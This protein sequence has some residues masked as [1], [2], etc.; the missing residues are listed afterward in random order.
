MLS[1]CTKD[2]N[3]E[4]TTKKVYSFYSG[5]GTLTLETHS[6]KITVISE[7][8]YKYIAYS[9]FVKPFSIAGASTVSLGK[10][11]FISAG[12]FFLAAIDYVPEVEKPLFDFEEDKRKMIEAR[13]EN[14]IK[15]YPEFHKPFTKNHIIVEKT[16]SKISAYK[17]K[18]E[19][20]V[21]I[22]YEKNEYDNSI[23]VSREI[24]KDYYSTVY[25]INHV[26]NVITI[27]VSLVS[28]VSG[29]LVNKAF[30]K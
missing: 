15:M 11:L 5:Q 14:K 1:K 20:T 4:K 22:S 25:V 2:F 6:T 19:E 9:F 26:G 16:V 27:P 13:C 17:T 8:D 21:V 24:K 3:E 7:P 29:I 18:D 30:V 12:M 10:C 23:F 28:A